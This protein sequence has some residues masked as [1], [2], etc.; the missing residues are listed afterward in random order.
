MKV[1]LVIDMLKDFIEEDGALYCGEA[2]RKIIPFVADKIDEYRS[3]GGRVI[4]L[5]DAHQPDDKEFDM[6]GKHA[7]KGDEGSDV[8]EQL[9]PGPSDIV[10]EK[11]TFSAF[12]RTQL[13]EVLKGL[14]TEEIAIVGVCTSICVM[15]TVG[16]LSVRG[17]DTVVYKD[18]VADLDDKDHEYA[19]KRMERVYGAKII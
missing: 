17:Y 7:V 2:G 18:G 9:Q 14:D 13:E 4:Y 1:L 3:S 5:C 16:E 8:I 10:I 11:Y 19:L 6:F 12:Y 15:D